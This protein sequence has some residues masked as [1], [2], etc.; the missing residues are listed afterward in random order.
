[1]PRKAKVVRLRRDL[2]ATW[3]EALEEFLVLKRAQGAAPRTLKDYQAHV[4]RFFSRYPDCWPGGVKRAALDYMAQDASP[5]YYNLKREYLGAFF[6]W[7][8]REG[9]LSENPL[10]ALRKKRTEGREVALDAETLTRLLALPDQS[11]FAGLRDFALLCLQLDTGLR[12]SEALALLPRDFNLRTLEVTVRAEAAKTRLART[13]PISPATAE[14][15]AKLLAARPQS[16]GPK[17]PVFCTEDGRKMSPWTWTWRMAQYSQKLGVKVR[18]Y[19]LRHA[20]ALEYLRR[21]GSALALQKTLGHRDLT[22]TKRYVAL[23]QQDLR[24]EHSKAS[25]L[26]ALLPR[27]TRVRKLMTQ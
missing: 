6:A 21:G 17:T 9:L 3:Q 5:A 10:A 13:L 7:C 23:T 18:P 1:M 20:F 19:D 15:V 4:T 2:P 16:W 27:R 24:E 11:R 8:V 25:P 14:A 26:A 12:P 22:M